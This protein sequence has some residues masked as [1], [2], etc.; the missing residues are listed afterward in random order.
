MFP[1]LGRII[2]RT[3][4]AWLAAWILLWA[5]TR[6]AAP[7]WNDVAKDGQFNFL[8][9]A[10]PSR[11]GE[12]LLRSAFPGRRAE[13]SIVIVVAREGDRQELSDE[14][15]RFIAEKLRPGLERIAEKVGGSG[16]ERSG[17]TRRRDPA[18]SRD[19]GSSWRGRSPRWPS[20]GRSPACISS[21]SR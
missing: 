8:P 7:R 6:V 17:P 14:D 20:A 1:L 13:S 5:G 2:S 3:W 4:M 10:V 18:L 15:R 19:A 16:A 9:R 11:R 12:R 21:G